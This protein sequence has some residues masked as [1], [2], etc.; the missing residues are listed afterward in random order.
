MKKH[1]ENFLLIRYISN[2]QEIS[3]ILIHMY[4]Y[5]YIFIKPFHNLIGTP[6]DMTILQSAVIFLMRKMF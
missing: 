1:I 2:E 5:M 6:L 4:L 3:N